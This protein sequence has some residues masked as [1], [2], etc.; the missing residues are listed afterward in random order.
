MMPARATGFLASQMTQIGWVQGELRFIRVHDL[1][2][3]VGRTHTRMCAARPCS[4]KGVQLAHFQR[5]WLGDIHHVADGA[6]CRTGPD[7]ASSSGE[8][9]HA[10]GAHGVP[11]SGH[12]Q[13]LHLDGDG[14]IRL[15]DSL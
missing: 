9:A 4:V 11:I 13:G 7:D 8:I 5:V 2:A 14:S 6:Q 12:S 15:A 1:L 3:L 10:G